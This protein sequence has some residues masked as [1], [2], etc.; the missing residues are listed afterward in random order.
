VDHLVFASPD[1]D[2][3]V[4]HVETLLG[5]E[6]SPGGSHADFGT[7]NRLLG[8]GPGRYMEVVSIDPEQPSPVRSRWFGLDTLDA[9][10]L[11][12]WCEAVDDLDRLLER[13]RTV[14]IDLGEPMS[15]RRRREDGTLLTWRMTDPWAERA[16]G[17]IPFFIDWGDTPHPGTVLPTSCSFLGIRGEHPQADQVRDWCEALGLDID[18]VRGEDVRLVA[19]LDS[20]NGVVDLS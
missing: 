9:P 7:R 4:G 1:L 11:V 8:F 2:V 15:G 19:T 16:G 5:V 6:M 20:P 13:A 10:R 18:V 3:G 14:G 12:T 17:V